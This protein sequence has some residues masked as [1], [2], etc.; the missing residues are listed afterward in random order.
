MLFDVNSR[1][2]CFVNVT[3]CHWSQAFLKWC[4]TVSLSLHSRIGVLNKTVTRWIELTLSHSRN[5]GATR[6]C[7]VENGHL[8]YCFTSRVVVFGVVI[9]IVSLRLKHYLL[10]DRLLGSWHLL[11]KSLITFLQRRENMAALVHER[12]YLGLLLAFTEMRLLI[13]QKFTFRLVFL[14][15]HH[16]SNSRVFSLSGEVWANVVELFWNQDFRCVE[17]LK[18]VC[19]WST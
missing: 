18:R 9:E 16:A 8:K 2:G 7:F 11:V 14:N 4:Q 1:F 3:S 19:L 6:L 5:Q 12:Q 10:T 13:G 15:R 17:I